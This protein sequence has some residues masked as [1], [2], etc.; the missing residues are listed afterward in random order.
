[1]E[2]FICPG[3]GEEI[4]LEELVEGSCPLCQKSCSPGRNIPSRDALQSP[5]ERERW[6]ISLRGRGQAEGRRPDLLRCL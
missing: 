1:M 6:L 5:E 2:G 4:Y 3:C